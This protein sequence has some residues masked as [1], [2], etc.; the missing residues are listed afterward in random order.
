MA[1]YYI[2]A[3]TGNDTT[4]NGSSSTPWLTLSKAISSSATTDTIILQSATNAYTMSGD[5]NLGS[6]TFT[7]VSPSATRVDA[8][9]ASRQ[10]IVTPASSTPTVNNIRFTNFLYS[11][12]NKAVFYCAV[13]SC[14]LT[15]ND[16]QFDNIS[17]YSDNN[18]NSGAVFLQFNNSEGSTNN[19]NRC[20]F[21]NI[22]KNAA[23]SNITCVLSAAANGAVKPI[24]NIT[25]C[26]FYISAT[27][28]T[29]LAYF[30]GTFS[31]YYG[32]YNIKNT[33]IYQTDTSVP[34]VSN[35][36]TQTTSYSDII[37]YSSAPTGTGVI[38]SDPLFIDAANNNFKLR[39]TSPC[40]GTGTLV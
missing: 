8:G 39:P 34:F 9:G 1:T 31:L 32:V 2:N 25:G 10:F 21:Y 11:S 36:Y 26:T 28:T 23:A 18:N 13:P 12:S 4:G 20:L 6:R 15:V 24:T 3:D 5:L 7:G 30:I 38:S 17:V 19:I 37:G 40:I 33:I 16:C 29:K 27:G 35:T 14:N 22:K